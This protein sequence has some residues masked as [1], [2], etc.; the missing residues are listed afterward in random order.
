[1]NDR[2]LENALILLVDDEVTMLSAMSQLLTNLGFKRVVKVHN[3]ELLPALLTKV[4]PDVV[5]TDLVMPKVDGFA[6]MD[7]LRARTD[8][9]GFLP[10]LVLTG[11]ATEENKRRA[12]AAGATDFLA[13]PFAPYEFL[14][15]LRNLIRLRLQAVA[16]RE[17]AAIAETRADEQ[18]AEIENAI[19]TASAAGQQ[20]VQQE[21]IRAFEAMAA[22]LGQELEGP[23]ATV[24]RTV[25]PLLQEE[26]RQGRSARLEPLLAIHTAGRRAQQTLSALRAFQRGRDESDDY[27]PVNLRAVMAAALKVAEAKWIARFAPFQHPIRVSLHLGQVPEVRGSAAELQEAMIHLLLNAAEAMPTGGVMEI[28]TEWREETATVIVKDHGEGMGDA[29]RRHCLDPFFTTKGGIGGGLGLP[30]VLGIVRRH[31]GRLEFDSERG[32]G[33]TFRIHLPIL[34]TVAS[35]IAPRR[36]VLVVGE[37]EHVTQLAIRHVASSNGAVDTARDGR[38][39][40][41]K[42][43][44]RSYDAII[45]RQRMAGMSGV[46]MAREIRLRG[47]RTPIVLLT[48]FVLSE[49]P[50]RDLIH[51]MLRKPVGDEVIAHALAS[52]LDLS[53]R[54]QSTE[55]QT[56]RAVRS[57]A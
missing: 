24:V 39:A 31:E 28:V 48:D 56:E 11:N 12:Y 45:T 37:D 52:C 55:N 51:S 18:A 43:N 5:I 25:E 1:M 41:L 13:K 16:L 4:M 15:R 30:A 38:D 33:T 9:D 29:T 50:P 57:A 23:L 6:V 8:S 17:Q 49:F 36:R 53:G 34:K 21:R 7:L 3:S 47:H 20:L 27:K 44:E 32:R 26:Q 40:L 42:L 2:D 14:P 54:D 35:V 10:V 22:G 19:A 46:E